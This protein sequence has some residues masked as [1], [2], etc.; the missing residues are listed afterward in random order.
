MDHSLFLFHNLCCVDV[1]MATT[2]LLFNGE[3]GMT[4]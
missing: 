4:P 2:T 1:A 3:V